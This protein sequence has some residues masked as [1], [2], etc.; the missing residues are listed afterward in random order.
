MIMPNVSRFDFMYV[1]IN[2]ALLEHM[3]QIL[4][5]MHLNNNLSLLAEGEWIFGNFPSI[6]SM[7]EP[8][9]VSG[10][11]YQGGDGGC[12]GWSSLF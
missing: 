2:I 11:Q 10:S 4:E 12:G 9:S 8:A 3:R 1:H 7:V 5:R 6:G